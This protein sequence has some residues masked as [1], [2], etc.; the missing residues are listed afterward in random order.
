MKKFNL[1]LLTIAG[2]G[3]MILTSCKKEATNNTIKAADEINTFIW[4]SMR[5][6]YLWVDNV[7]N[8]TNSNYTYNSSTKINSDSLNAFL[9]KYSDHDKLFDALL[10]QPGTVDKWSVLISDYVA[11][12]KELSGTYKT[13]GYDFM[14]MRFGT[15]DNVLGYVRY[16]IKGSP[17]DLAG[18]KR[19]YIF[20]QVNDQ[21]LTTTN[22]SD[23]LLNSESYKL[24]FVNIVN[25][26]LSLNGITATMSAIELTEDP[27]FMDSVYTVNNQK[28]GYLVYNSFI[29]E[30][31]SELNDVFLKFKNEG[32]SKLILDLRYN[33]GGS[34]QSAI[35]LSSMIYG[36]YTDK[37]FLKTS[38]NSLLQSYLTQNYGAGYFNESFSSNIVNSD[39]SETP[40]N[41]LNLSDVY[42][43]TTD[44][45]ASASEIVI[46]GLKPY[47]NVTTVGTNTYGKYVAS[48]I[49]NDYTDSQGTINPNHTYALMPIILKIS[50]SEGVSDFVN[51][52]TPQV[53][54]DEDITNMSVLGDLN[55]PLLNET[56][57]LIESGSKK[58]GRVH[59]DLPLT[60]IGSQK[61]FIPH[62]HEMYFNKKI[63]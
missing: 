28:I 2:I 50:N 53:V 26:N 54:L 58:A 29:P 57:S 48:M 23:L 11:L 46:N 41:T 27:I 21:Q 33:G 56:I 38:Y 43:I 44:N 63:K 55:E 15:G 39:Y 52:F 9:N 51:G 37:I 12:E 42:I 8:L 30:Y 45:T 14:L 22:Y 47:I 59:S 7:S 24:S 49:L 35:Y 32:V 10:Y 34:V 40:I 18:V 6:Y 36:T 60:K 4:K 16:V 1:F 25:N 20:T 5:S 17:A 61:E 31:D 62:M 13:M 3:F 19:G